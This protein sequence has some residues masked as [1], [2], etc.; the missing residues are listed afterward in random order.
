[1]LKLK[2]FTRGISRVKNF[3]SVLSAK[4]KSEKLEEIRK[5]WPP[6]KWP[7]DKMAPENVATSGT[8][9]LDAR[10]E[11]QQAQY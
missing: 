9:K 5:Y 8:L 10:R 6:A 1:M 4:I 7:N 3:S 2:W 11:A